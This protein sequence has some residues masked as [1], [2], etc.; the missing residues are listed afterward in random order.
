MRDRQRKYSRLLAATVL[1]AG[2][3]GALASDPGSFDR[4]LAVT[5]PVFLDVKSD[6]GG[7]V[8]TTGPEATV[9]VHAIIKPLFGRLDLDLAEANIRALEKDPPIEQSGNRIRIGYVKDPSLLRGV[10]IRFEIE[11]PQASEVRAATTSGGI[12]IDGIAGPANTMTNSGRTEISNVG[13]SIN[14]GVGSGAVIIRNAGNSVV[15]RSQSGGIQLTGIRG[16]AEL[17]TSSGRHEISDVGGPLRATTNSGSIRIE[18]ARAG[19][20]ARNSSGS[21]TALRI[22]GSVHAET[23][24]GEIRIEQVK[25]APIRAVA[26]S[27]AIHV[28]LASGGGYLLEALSHSGKISAPAEVAAQLA[29]DGHSLKAQLGQGGPLVDLDTQSSRIAIR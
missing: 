29:R 15:V 8:I 21:I 12:R 22:G 13:A 23:G 3:S 24:S 17:Q 20:I 19:V 16:S 2:A 18:D 25:P 11:T 9:R 5:G 7:A 27:G 1:L 26:R 4:T 14:V 6:P 28:K 10:T